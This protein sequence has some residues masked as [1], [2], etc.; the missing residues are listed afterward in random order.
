MHPL[1]ALHRHGLTSSALQQHCS[2]T[3][4]RNTAARHTMSCPRV[5]FAC[6]SRGTRA[7][8]RQHFGLYWRL[9]QRLPLLLRTAAAAAAAAASHMPSPPSVLPLTSLVLGLLLQMGCTALHLAAGRGHL[10]GAEQ[11][12][13]WAADVDSTDKVRPTDCQQFTPPAGCMGADAIQ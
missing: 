12:L 5:L 10:R 4:Q 2:A 7:A 3:L 8:G 13:D 1:R 11:L 6:R 9:Q